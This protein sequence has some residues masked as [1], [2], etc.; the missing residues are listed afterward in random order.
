MIDVKHEIANGLEKAKWDKENQKLVLVYNVEGERSTKTHDSTLKEFRSV[1][2]QLASSKSK[3]L[4]KTDNNSKAGVTT[5]KPSTNDDSG[6]VGNVSWKPANLL[7]VNQKNDDV[8]LEWHRNDPANIQKSLAEHYDFATLNDVHDPLGKPTINDTENTGNRITRREMVLMKMS[9]Q[10]WKAR[11]AYYE[12]TN[13]ANE[14]ESRSFELGAGKGTGVIDK[15]DFKTEKVY[16][17]IKQK[18]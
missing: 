10:M 17:Q 15:T 6:L 13:I 11:L 8:V 16:A 12:E 4:K 5:P 2:A 3:N 1:N 14:I 7:T 9:K 18:K